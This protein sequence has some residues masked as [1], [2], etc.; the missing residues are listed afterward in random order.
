MSESLHQ[1]TLESLPAKTQQKLQRGQVVLQG[2]SGQYRVLVL[3]RAAYDIAWSVLTDYDNFD[4]FLPTVVSSRVLEQ[5]GNRNIV[6]QVDRRKIILLG[7][8]E[9][10]V[11]TENVEQDGQIDFRLLQGDLQTMEGYWRLD[12]L[13]EQV[14]V[15]QQVTA[16]ADLGPFRGMFYTLFADSLVHTMRAIRREIERRTR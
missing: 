9:S 12:S 14:L 16:E 3:A 8:M 11:R 7:K 2:S 10:T 13:P 6:E 5:D 15:T 4:R 1:R